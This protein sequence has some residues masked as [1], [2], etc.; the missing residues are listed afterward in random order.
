MRFRISACAISK[1]RPRPSGCGGRFAKHADTELAAGRSRVA[2]HLPHVGRVIMSASGV[3]RPGNMAD[4]LRLE[5]LRA[6]PLE[7]EPFEHLVVPGF[8]TEAGL[9]AINADYPKISSPGSFPTDQLVFGATFQTFL[10]E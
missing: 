8:V 1:C 6:T 7:R 5:T 3:A 2:F 4:Y 9:A 10:D